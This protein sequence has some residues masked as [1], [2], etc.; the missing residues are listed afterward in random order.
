MMARSAEGSVEP[1]VAETILK[2]Q[3]GLEDPAT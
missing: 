3:L 2:K 1:D